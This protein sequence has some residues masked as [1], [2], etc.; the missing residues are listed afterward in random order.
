MYVGGCVY[1]VY[2]IGGFFGIA[3][4]ISLVHTNR[5]YKRIVNGYNLLYGRSPKKQTEIHREKI[6]PLE[7]RFNRL[8]VV[9]TISSIG[10]VVSLSLIAIK[11]F[12]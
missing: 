2:I 10:F 9:D 8:I 6:K 1:M 11:I 5:V 3:L 7:K 4:A 12:N